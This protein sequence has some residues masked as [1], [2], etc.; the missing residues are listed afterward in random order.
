MD[1][2]RLRSSAQSDR[3][4]SPLPT[5]PSTTPHQQTRKD[6]HQNTSV[7]EYRPSEQ[8]AEADSIAPDISNPLV[9]LHVTSPSRSPSPVP[10]ASGI[11]PTKAPALASSVPP[12]PFAL[13]SGPGGQLVRDISLPRHQPNTICQAIFNNNS[14]V[15]HNAPGGTIVNNNSVIQVVSRDQAADDMN[16]IEKCKSSVQTRSTCLNDYRSWTS[17][18]FSCAL[19]RP[20]ALFRLHGRNPSSTAQ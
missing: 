12:T 9:A 7:V 13:I 8:L 2:L 6:H 19:R 3:S 14:N 16:T 18:R 11:A 15:N 1:R 4:S 5:S 10:L 17:P 20:A